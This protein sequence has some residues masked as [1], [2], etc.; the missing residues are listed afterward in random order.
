MYII[1]EYHKLYQTY[2]NFFNK[3]TRLCVLLFLIFFFNFI[4]IFMNFFLSISICFTLE[5]IIKI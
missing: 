3:I 2:I 1:I 4:D 5:H